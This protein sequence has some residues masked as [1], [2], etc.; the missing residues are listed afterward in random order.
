M[1]DVGIVIVT[2]NSGEEIGACLDAAMRTGAEIVVV[3]NASDDGSASQVTKRGLRL[4]TNVSNRG[5]AGGV[6]QG[7][8]ALATPFILLLNPDAVIQMG[9]DVL[10]ETCSAPQVAAVGGMLVDERGQPQVGFML[11]RFPTAAALCFEA[12][13]INRLW[14]RNKV[15]WQY[16]CLDLDHTAPSEVEQPAGAF[17]M[18]R[19]SA[20]EAVGG[21]DESFHP[22]WFEDVDFL[23]RIKDRGYRIYYEP[24]A[25]A[26]HTGGHSI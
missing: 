4:I 24:K 21:L 6:N 9:I 10:R 22:L 20:W 25:V 5:F 19:R 14:P 3:D 13:L 15:N 11:R 17:L 1:P 26:K 18:F 7:V 16:R 23:K 12:L 8:Q 2:H